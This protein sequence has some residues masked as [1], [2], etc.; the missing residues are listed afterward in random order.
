ML[1][2]DGLYNCKPNWVMLRYLSHTRFSCDRSCLVFVYGIYLAYRGVS[3]ESAFHSSRVTCVWLSL[4]S[5]GDG[6]MTHMSVYMCSY[7][8]V[9]AHNPDFANCTSVKYLL[10]VS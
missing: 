10:L 6:Q 4:L 1:A 8:S 7:T 3:W 2:L 9:H 5:W